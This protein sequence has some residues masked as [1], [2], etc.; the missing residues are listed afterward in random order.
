MATTIPICRGCARPVVLYYHSSLRPTFTRISSRPFATAGAKTPVLK[1][2]PKTNLGSVGSAIAPSMKTMQTPRLSYAQQLAEK[3][4]PT[5]LYEVGPQRLTLFSSYLAGLF[6]I[7]AGG[8]NMYWNVYNIPDGIHWFVP[9]T[10]GVAG[11]IMAALGTRFALI[12]AGSI[13]SIKVLSARAANTS[14]SA[15]KTASSASVPVRLEIKARRS[16]PVPGFSLQRL[17][18]D[19]NDVVLPVPMYHRKAALSDYDKMLMKQ[20]EEAR[21]KKERDYEMSHLMT[22]P[23]RHARQA[24]YKLFV[25]LRRGL[26]G[27]GYLPIT[28]DGV[29]YKLDITSAYALED[30]RALD[31]IVK[32]KQRLALDRLA[33][34]SK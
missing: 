5:T 13:H 29:R 22:A 26:T 18:A 1:Q 34:K 17:Q 2:K 10:C 14:G 24:F 28:V 31:R 16:V 7:T 33:Q 25:G 4:S 9:A 3:P 11:I 32:I 21:V 15:V 6:C 30:G 19:P 23:F 8:I 12:P 27:E 20:A